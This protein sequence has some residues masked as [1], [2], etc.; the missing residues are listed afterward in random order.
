MGKMG[1][2]VDKFLKGYCYNQ[3]VVYLVATTVVI[4]C[5][6]GMERFYSGSY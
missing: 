3:E 6:C 5:H 2:M 1:F 4:Y